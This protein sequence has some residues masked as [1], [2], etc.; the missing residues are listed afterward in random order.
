MKHTKKLLPVAIAAL[1]FS[2]CQKN[3]QLVG[4]ISTKKA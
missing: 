2:A 4:E 3:D 1:I